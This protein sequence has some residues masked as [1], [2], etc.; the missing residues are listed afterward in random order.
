MFDNDAPPHLY[1]TEETARLSHTTPSRIENW[2]RLAILI[3]DKTARRGTGSRGYALFSVIEAARCGLL[4]DRGVSSAQ[5]KEIADVIRRR[6]GV[7]EV[8]VIQLRV[9]FDGLRDLEI[10]FVVAA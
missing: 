6:R 2:T 10:E 8:D 4:A 7:H 1:T 9:Y 3:P 5:L